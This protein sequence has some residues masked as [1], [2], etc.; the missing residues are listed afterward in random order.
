MNPYVKSVK[1]QE[2][3]CLLLTFENGEKRIFDLRPYLEKPVFRPLRNIALFKTARVVSGSVEWPGDVDLS[4]DTVYVESKP[5]KKP[6]SRR[7]T[8]GTQ[9]K[10]LPMATLP[11]KK[12]SKARA[13]LK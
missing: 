9:K 4:Y 10:S 11:K 5:S 6:Q 12:P 8:T 2:D 13:S 7:K 3:Y 1:P